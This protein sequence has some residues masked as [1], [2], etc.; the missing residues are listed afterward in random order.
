MVAV[1]NFTIARAVRE[2][3]FVQVP[4]VALR[5]FQSAAK[6]R[7]LDTLGF[8]DPAP[9]ETL[10]RENLLTPIAYALQASGFTSRPRVLPTGRC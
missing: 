6:A 7:G 9:W 8:L 10:D 2:W 4:L 3:Y 1:G 5:D